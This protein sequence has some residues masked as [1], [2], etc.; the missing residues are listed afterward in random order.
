M[1]MAIEQPE[2]PGVDE[3]QTDAVLERPHRRERPPDFLLTQDDWQSGLALRARHVEHG[4]MAAKRVL[5]EELEA[6]Q[7]L[8]E[9]ARGDLPNGGEVEQIVAELFL[10]ELIGRG[11]VELGDLR[12]RQ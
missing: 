8:R 4:P 1:R 5:I 3:G 12:D 7:G 10:G 6:T 9:A 2:A 11:P